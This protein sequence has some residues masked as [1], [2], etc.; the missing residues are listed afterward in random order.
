MNPIAK[1]LIRTL[2]VHRNNKKDAL[3][4]RGP[5]LDDHYST[6]QGSAMRNSRERFSE[7]KARTRSRIAMQVKGARSKDRTANWYYTGSSLTEASSLFKVNLLSEIKS[8]LV[9]SK[10]KNYSVLDI[11][12]GWGQSE[13]SSEIAFSLKKS[14]KGIKTKVFGLSVTRRAESVAPKDVS[15]HVGHAENLT[16]VFKNGK[17]VFRPN[18]VDFIYSSWGLLHSADIDIALNECRKI[19]K[20]GGRVIFN[21]EEEIPIVPQGF[22]LV[23]PTT[24]NRSYMPPYKYIHY[25]EKK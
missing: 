7:K 18:T 3:L 24:I 17:P 14:F 4:Q 9:K 2:R 8:H 10:S 5:Y 19:L 25:F 16:R 23:R 20:K 13:L 21:S 1:R 15:L 22:K 6:V 11:G 12:T